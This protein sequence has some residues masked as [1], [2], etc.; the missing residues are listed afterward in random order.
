MAYLEKFK[1]DWADFL[2]QRTHFITQKLHQSKTYDN[3]KIAKKEAEQELRERL[4]EEGW[5]VYEQWYSEFDDV[6]SLKEGLFQEE[7]YILGF[8]D[9]FNFAELANGREPFF[10]EDFRNK[11]KAENDSINNGCA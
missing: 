6:Y 10:A 2:Q 5:K 9:G 3:L 11:L 8:R 4:G 7:L 1:E